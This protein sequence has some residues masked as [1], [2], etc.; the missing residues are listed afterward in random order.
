MHCTRRLSLATI[1]R[2]TLCAT[3]SISCAYGQADE[4]ARKIL[5]LTDVEQIQFVRSTLEEGLPE[6]RADRM[7]M[8]TINR[9]TIT[10]PLIEESIEQA[11]KLEPPSQK[12]VEVAAE[13][14]AYAGDENALNAIVKLVRIDKSRFARLVGRALTHSANWRNPFTLAYRS[15]QMGDETV[16]QSTTTWVESV[17]T[18]NRMRRAWAE[19][20]LE[21]YGKIPGEAEWT[22]DPIISRL[23]GRVS[24]E[25]RQS[26][27]R[28]AAEAQE[29]RR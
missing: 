9:S 8:L 16:S 6:S 18:S 11:L 27:L 29:G 28:F 13:L 15:L 22:L 1:L 14:I 3:C 17:L 21:K 5:E 2:L 20:M 12:F 25:L 19:A 24:S 23:K 10:L 26:I 7:T 4:P